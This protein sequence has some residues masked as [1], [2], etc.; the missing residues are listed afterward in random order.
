MKKLL[1]VLVLL[2]YAAAAVVVYMNM[3]VY[4][5]SKI[6]GVSPENN[7]ARLQRAN[8][9]M[10]FSD[11]T[12]AEEGKV[13]LGIALENL[14]HVEQAGRSLHKAEIL[15]RRA[16]RFNPASS[17][18]HFYYAK[19]LQYLSFISE[20]RVPDSLAELWKAARLAGE[21]SSL[22]FDIVQALLD[23]WP[24]LSPEQ[25]HFTLQNLRKILAEGNESQF[26]T[27]LHVWFLNVK[28]EKLLDS[29]LPESS[30]LYRTYA[31]FLGEMSLSPE[32]RQRLL[33]KA[34]DLDYNQ[35]VRENDAG[36]PDECLRLLDGIHFYAALAEKKDIAPDLIKH[37]LLVKA[38]TLSRAKLRLMKTRKLE[39]AESDLRAYLK[40][41]TDYSQVLDL[42][43]YL[44][45]INLVPGDQ[46]VRPVQG[47][48]R[49]LAF[50]FFLMF[51]AHKYNQITALG[52][53]LGGGLIVA[54]ETQKRYIREILMI[55]ADSYD[56]LNF[57]YEPE[58]FYQKALEAVP[59][60][61]EVLL[62]LRRY[63][64]RM[65]D[66]SKAARVNEALSGVL[67][68]PAVVLADGLVGKEQTWTLPFILDS[69][70]IILTLSFEL[71]EGENRPL[72]TVLFN[73]RVIW[74]DTLAA[75]DLSL[76]VEATP[77]LNRLD[78]IPVNKPVRLLGWKW[79]EA[80]A[81][82]EKSTSLY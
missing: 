16:L 25:R 41:E 51:C 12:L 64:E 44:K 40:M 32:A 3:D 22:D 26:R 29:I 58:R 50:E 33:A 72:I 31:R 57:V 20:R 55:V 69:S 48:L 28:D 46:A 34:E 70:S 45:E 77:G 53:G 79:T 10:P 8:R 18:N 81:E 24:S 61:W 21:R 73:G 52:A 62:K 27:L 63:Y 38:A 47:D 75:P 37:Q 80:V 67:T 59:N 30:K 35:A 56:K 1:L 5:Q 2:A 6:K 15:L 60:D 42:E 74:E 82:V 19:A 14:A 54:D 7:L 23:R 17:E 66:T 39:D 11:K 78:I 13:R 49:H 71:P 76:K 36:H 68:P 43:S 65:N 4:Y 9:L